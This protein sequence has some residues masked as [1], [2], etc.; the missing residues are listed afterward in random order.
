MMWPWTTKKDIT[1]LLKKRQKEIEDNPSDLIPFTNVNELLKN[2]S[3][4]KPSLLTRLKWDLHEISWK[5]YRY[6][7]PAHKQIRNSIPRPWTDIAELIHIVNFEFVKSFYEN[8]KDS[9]DWIATGEP[10]AD[11]IKWLE[12]AYNYITTERPK[13]LEEISQSYPSFEATGSY[14][15]KYGPLIK[16]ENLLNERDTEVLIEIVKRRAFFWS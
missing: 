9:T 12:R 2:R 11:F 6:F 5:V 8:E 10:A 14:E 3:Q 13:I 15:E 1:N 16:L 7:I 4:Y